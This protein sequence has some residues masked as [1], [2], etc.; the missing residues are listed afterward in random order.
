MLIVGHGA[1]CRLVIDTE[2]ALGVGIEFDSF[3][4]SQ[5]V[6]ELAVI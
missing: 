3:L 5:L 2:R 6:R 4:P 1:L